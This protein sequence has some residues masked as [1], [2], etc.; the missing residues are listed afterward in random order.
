MGVGG[1]DAELFTRLKRLRRELADARK[2]PAYIVFSDAVLVQMAAAKPRTQSA[3]LAVSGVGP[4]KL[5]LYGDAF[6][7]VLRSAE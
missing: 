6:L 2:V 3:L 5:T 4:K 1:V 7:E